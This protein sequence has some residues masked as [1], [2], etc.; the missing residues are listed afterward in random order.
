MDPASRLSTSSG[1]LQKQMCQGTGGRHERAIS[2]QLSG[3]QNR[4]K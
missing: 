3:N 2:S 4:K 1:H